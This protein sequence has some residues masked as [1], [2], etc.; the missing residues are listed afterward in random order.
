MSRA[1]GWWG[2]TVGAV[3]VYASAVLLSLPPPLYF[4][5]RLGIWS[6]HTLPDEPAIS[7]YGRLIYATAGGLAGM[8]I[9]RLV[10]RRFPPRLVS[11][12]A[13]VALLVLAWHERHWFLR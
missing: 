11:W 9:G 2:A 8:L 4:F 13:I 7:W 10:G 6:V 12:S 3:L 1:E 5:P